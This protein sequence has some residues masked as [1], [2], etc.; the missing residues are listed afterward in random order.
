MTLGTITILTAGTLG[1][2]AAVITA[3]A[4]LLGLLVSNDNNSSD[5]GI[6]TANAGKPQT[7]NEGDNVILDGFG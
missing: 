4:G 7:V 2:I 3:I 6:P 5:N 1:G